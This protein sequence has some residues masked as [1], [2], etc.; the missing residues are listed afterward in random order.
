MNKILSL[1]SIT[2]LALVSCQTSTKTESNEN[3]KYV[4]VSE[5]EIAQ[6]ELASKGKTLME[7]QC[8][9]CQKTGLHLHLLRLKIII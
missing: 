4:D 6:T 9:V 7:N 2:S 3:N 8:Y 1:I 5:A